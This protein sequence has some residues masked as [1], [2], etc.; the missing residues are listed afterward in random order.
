MNLSR[1]R[2][3]LKELVRGANVET[4]HTKS[5]LVATKIAID[6]LRERPDYYE[7]LARVEQAPPERGF[8]ASF[9]FPRRR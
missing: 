7:L 4:E 6:H 1:E 5:A 3:S 8:F 2:F 9:W